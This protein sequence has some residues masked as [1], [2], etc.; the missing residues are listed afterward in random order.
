VAILIALKALGHI[1]LTNENFA[2]PQFVVVE[3]AFLH[4]G[5]SFLL[6]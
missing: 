6:A 1:A 3:E 5:V 2:V 4:E